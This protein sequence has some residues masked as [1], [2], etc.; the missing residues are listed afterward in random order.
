MF[1]WIRLTTNQIY[2]FK[3]KFSDDCSYPGWIKLLELDRHLLSQEFVQMNSFVSG[4]ER[5]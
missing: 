3:F 2:H 4:M 1:M 5:K